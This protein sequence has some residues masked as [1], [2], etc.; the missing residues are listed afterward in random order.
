MNTAIVTP[1][2]K[3]VKTKRAAYGFKLELP[4]KFTIRGLIRQKRGTI[5]YITLY[6]RVEK[7]LKD[8]T[9]AVGGTVTPKTAKRGRPETIFVRVNAKTPAVTTEV[10]VMSDMV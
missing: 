5:K 9:L 7:G 8:G 3:N 1:A 4:Q 2:I 6:K 10:A